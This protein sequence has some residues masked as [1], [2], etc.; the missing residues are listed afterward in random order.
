VKYSQFDYNIVKL[1]IFTHPFF[2][3]SPSVVLGSRLEAF[4][5]LCAA[6]GEI[7][8]RGIKL[9]KKYPA[10]SLQKSASETG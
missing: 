5:A 10:I 7:F 2:P 3:P 8:F 1:T 9:Q 4:L 6:P